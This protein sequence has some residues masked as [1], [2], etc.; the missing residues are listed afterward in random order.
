MLRLLGNF[1]AQETFKHVI[2][3]KFHVIYAVSS[4]MRHLMLLQVT[5]FTANK[6]D[7]SSKNEK[8]LWRGK[9]YYLIRLTSSNDNN[10]NTI[11]S[12]TQSTRRTTRESFRH[13]VFSCNCLG[14]LKFSRKLMAQDASAPIYSISY[15]T[16][17][18]LA[19]LSCIP[20][21]KILIRQHCWPR[22]GP[23][24]SRGTLTCSYEKAIG[25]SV[26]KRRMFCFV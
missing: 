15:K 26:S 5:T 1:G 11:F 23:T 20:S 19:L 10:C 17:Q 16:R 14:S 4:R 12:H 3:N 13:F 8:R 24:P 25:P 2:M 18:S 9:P 22:Q 21:K 6:I 7:L